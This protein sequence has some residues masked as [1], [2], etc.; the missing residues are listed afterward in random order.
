MQGKL[1]QTVFNNKV[2]EVGNSTEKISV[3]NL[4]AGTIICK[5]TLA[6]GQIITKSLL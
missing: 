4:K 1:I 3:E 6:S 2:I 5:F